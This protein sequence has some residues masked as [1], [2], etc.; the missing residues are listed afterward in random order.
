[1]K[2]T[3]INPAIPSIGSRNLGGLSA[4]M[5]ELFNNNSRLQERI[6]FT[7]KS[8]S[9]MGI[10]TIA[11]LVPDDMDV[12]FF[13]ENME[14][15]DY[16]SMDFDLVAIGGNLDQVNRSISLCNMFK[17][18]NIPV[19]V[20]GTG[21]TTLPDIF[22]NNKIPVILGEAENLFPIFLEDFK[23]GEIRPVYDHTI[24]SIH[25]DLDK[26]PL[27]R[28]DLARKYPYTM[29]GV[30]A[31]RGCPYDCSFCQV[32]KLY[33]RK[34]R[35]KP[36]DRI[37][38]EVKIVK[39]YWPDSFFF[40]YDDNPFAT[41]KIALEIFD[42]LN[43]VEKISLGHWGTN[44]NVN[45][46]KDQELVDVLTAKG[47]I[48]FL[49]IGFESL[50]PRNLGTINNNMKLNN[51]EIY[52]HAVEQFRANKI[53]PIGYFMF[54]FEYDEP[55][56]M[57][58]IVKFILD[59]KLDVQLS[60]L[61]PMPGTQLYMDLKTEFEENRGQIKKSSIAEWGTIK[62]YFFNKCT[63]KEKQMQQIMENAYSVVFSDKHF[64]SEVLIPTIFLM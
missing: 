32:T 54:G 36:V 4:P 11:G 28:Y 49:G 59:N 21:A 24:A 56:D 22:I 7:R 34:F 51:V 12:E 20:G 45:L 3:F 35:Y 53:N 6:D 23:K 5:K 64:N 40:F 2:I 37:I 57:D 16:D 58:I 52:S 26:S 17:K 38:E 48:S 61:T 10:I 13:D 43:N 15:V 50:S 60:R 31:S 8:F 14:T 63:I 29:V 42:R 18:R 41:K 55:E 9:A 19:I 30:Q 39:E 27:P 44:A 1:M 46:Y 33:G 25:I 62:K 47:P